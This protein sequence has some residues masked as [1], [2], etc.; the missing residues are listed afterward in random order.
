[1]I[2]SKNK[3]WG[4]EPLNLK[5]VIVNVLSERRSVDRPR[6]VVDAS[7][8]VVVSSNSVVAASKPMV[9]KIEI[10]PVDASSYRA[11]IIKEQNDEIN[12]EDDYIDEVNNTSEI[13]EIIAESTI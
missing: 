6:K 8:Q 9:I 13:N 10:V 4:S 2:F 11:L 5:I 3:R 1:M 7:T 12:P